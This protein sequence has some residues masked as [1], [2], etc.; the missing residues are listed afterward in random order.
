MIQLTKT[1]RG[2]VIG[3]FSDLYN[4]PASIQ[5]SSLADEDCI[6]LGS[7]AGRMHLTR[8]MVSELLPLLAHFVENGDLRLPETEPAP[9]PEIGRAVWIDYTNYRK[10]RGIR[11]IVPL[12]LEYRESEYHKADG[13]QWILV[14]WDPAKEAERDFAMKDVHS[15]EPTA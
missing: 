14:G 7:E 2:F 6:W 8:G 1:G 13:E 5:E 12:R 15:W 4:Q 9:V 10:E 3:E 11:T